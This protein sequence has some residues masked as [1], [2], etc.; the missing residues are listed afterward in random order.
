VKDID[1]LRVDLIQHAANAF[2]ALKANVAKLPDTV[3]ERAGLVMSR[4]TVVLDRL[5]QLATQPTDALRTRIHG[6]YHLG[7]VLR[8]KGDFVI[9]DF[10][11]EPARSLAERRTKQS[12][13]KD[14]AGMLR[15][16]SY[17]AF[18]ALIKYST[19]RPEDFSRL[20]PWAKLWEQSVSS[21]FLRTYC[22]SVRG[23]PVIP[24]DPQQFAQLLEAF[25]I[26]KALYELTYELN[27]RPNW[28]VIP[29][30]GI[31]AL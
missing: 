1:A 9:L 4:R 23:V 3:L 6:D 20:E 31:L 17:A 2:D 15:S 12:P 26:D 29:L 25:V 13:L 14:V 10:E 22:E 21:A 18:S 30:T 7:Q 8:S 24:S 27:N 16:F 19:R 28:V 5:R 11:G